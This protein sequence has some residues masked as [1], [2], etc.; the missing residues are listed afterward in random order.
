MKELG[1][2]LMIA[3]ALIFFVIISLYVSEL[4]TVI[5]LASLMGIAGLILVKK[6]KGN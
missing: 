1:Y 6:D 4:F 5:L 3:S 2:T